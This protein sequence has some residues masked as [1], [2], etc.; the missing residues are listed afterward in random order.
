V[1]CW[2]A[3]GQAPDLAQLEVELQ[4][5]WEV[6]RG[7]GLPLWISWSEAQLSELNF[8][9]G[10]WDK[11]VEHAQAACRPES[12]PPGFYI[13][14]TLFRQLAYAGDRAGAFAIL[15]DQRTRLPVAGQHN[16]ALGSWATLLFVVDGLVILGEQQQAAQLY[17]LAR[18]LVDTGAVFYWWIPRAVQTI[19]GVAAGAAR[20]W[21]AAE[22]HFQ[23]ALRQAESF[24]HRLEIAEIN[25]FH[26]AMLLDRNASQ[27]R[28]RARGLLNAALD[29]YTRIGMLRHVEISRTLLDRS[30]RS[31]LCGVVRC[32]YARGL[33]VIE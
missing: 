29:G 17:P 5:A 4:Q 24:P 3:F 26:A 22:E 2:T 21:D 28:E 31:R 11:A 25:R 8:I 20:N 6:G 16:T 30:E 12:R 1:Q 14:G 15:N 7:A 27:D 19:A 13:A 9:R 33:R 32:S 23:I 10:R 18:Q